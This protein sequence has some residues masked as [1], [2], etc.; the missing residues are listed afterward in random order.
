MWFSGPRL[1]SGQT[2]S[3]M[4]GSSASS[5]PTGCNGRGSPKGSPDELSLR[6]ASTW[7]HVQ[8]M[9]PAKGTRQTS[10]VDK[11]CG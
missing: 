3:V 10:P 4:Q 2:T 5:C 1:V 9:G 7:K 11:V 8:R 6:A